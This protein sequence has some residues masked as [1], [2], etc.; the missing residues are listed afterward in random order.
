MMPA[1]AL[2]LAGLTEF[3]YKLGLGFLV[4]CVS[5]VLLSLLGIKIQLH[6]GFDKSH[7]DEHKQN[8][9]LPTD[10]EQTIHVNFIQPQQAQVI[11]QGPAP[12]FPPQAYQSYYQPPMTGVQ[13]HPPMF[14]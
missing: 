5:I 9:L 4:Y 3:N 2:M 6:L 10:Q 8:V 13:Q 14:M 12:V 11:S 1:G 7:D